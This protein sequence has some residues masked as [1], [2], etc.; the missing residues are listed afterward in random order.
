MCV[1]G[2]FLLIAGLLFCVSIVWAAVG[3]LMMGFGLICLL[4][5]E[6]RKKRSTV[7]GTSRSD[8]VD[9]RVEPVLVLEPVD[10]QPA[11]LSVPRPAKISPRREPSL[12]LEPPKASAQP[13]QSA[14][15][16]PTSAA[17]RKQHVSR[18]QSAYDADKWRSLVESDA[19]I[20]RVVAALA[21][22]GRKYVDQL[23]TAYL[24]FD[25]KSHWE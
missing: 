23:A 8:E 10:E 14:Q 17:S 7:P 13:E 3:F 5:A 24:A 1:A 22:F 21:P 4:I 20:S 11:A 25:E 6:R 19:D 15:P 12:S 9:H 2:T 16:G 18:Q